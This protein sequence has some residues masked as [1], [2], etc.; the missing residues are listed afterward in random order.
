MVGRGARGVARPP[1][2]GVRGLRGGGRQPVGD[3]R[4]APLLRARLARGHGDRGRMAPAR[5]AGR[6]GPASVSRARLRGDGRDLRRTG[7]RR[8]R[9]GARVRRTRHGDRPALRRP[10]PGGGVDPHAGASDDRCRPDRRGHR[11]AR[12]GDDLRDRRGARRVLHRRH[13][14]QR[15][16]SLSGPRR[17]RASRRMERRRDRLVRFD[18]TRRAVQ[19][20]LPHQPGAGGGDARVLARG[21]VGGGDGCVGHHVRAAGGGARVLRERRA[22]PTDG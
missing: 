6:R 10:G 13:L 3:R 21:R 2:A 15:P 5:T 18:L 19:R 4:R 7:G 16:R 17:R 11:A 1:P 8:S 12:R 20:A 22:P 14:L 9:R